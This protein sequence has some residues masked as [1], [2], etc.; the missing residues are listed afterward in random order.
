MVLVVSWCGGERGNRNVL[1][2]VLTNKLFEYITILKKTCK[3]NIFIFFL[4]GVCLQNRYV[5]CWWN[6]SGP[7]CS[8]SPSS[9][10]PVI[11]R[12]SR[13]PGCHRA[14]SDG[15]WSTVA[16]TGEG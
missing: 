8:P 3:T 10:S 14:R 15:Q 1:T 4:F 9:L 6:K 7:Q 11:A 13:K 2:Y 12:L 16:A 5:P